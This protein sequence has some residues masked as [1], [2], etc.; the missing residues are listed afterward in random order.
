M[1]IGK[2]RK[3]AVL[4]TPQNNLQRAEFRFSDT[5]KHQAFYRQW[6]RCA[7]CGA[8]L[9]YKMDHAHHVIPV[10]SGKLNDQHDVFL[11]SLDNCVILCED[12]HLEIGHSGNF[13]KGPVA[14]P[15][16]FPYSHGQEKEAHK[17]WSQQLNAQWKRKFPNLLAIETP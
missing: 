9:I 8:N 4:P 15:V 13:T 12:C 2:K 3:K 14:M 17:T 6:N 11:K 7:Y 5:T 10:Q 16:T 1:P